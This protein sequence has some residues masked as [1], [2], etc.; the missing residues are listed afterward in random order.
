MPADTTSLA[1]AACALKGPLVPMF[2]DSSGIAVSWLKSNLVDN[3]EKTAPEDPKFVTTVE[4]A[5]RFGK[6]LLVED[7]V[8]LPP[9]I[10]PLLKHRPLKLGDRILPI[11]QGFKLFLSTRKDRLDNVPSEADAI[12]IYVSLGSDTSSLAERFIEKVSHRYTLS[13]GLLHLVYFVGHLERD[14]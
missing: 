4:L 7:I 13:I 2:I 8:D 9:I 1:G 3:L 14:P 5:V 10:L 12:L 11:Q 6:P